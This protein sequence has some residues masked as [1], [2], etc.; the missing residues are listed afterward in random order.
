MIELD[1]DNEGR[2]V[3]YMPM[4]KC[5]NCGEEIDEKNERCL[6]CGHDLKKEITTTPKRRGR[7][8]KVNTIKCEDCKIEYDIAL[9]ECPNCGCPKP[10]V[11]SN[12]KQAIFEYI[13]C[14]ECGSKISQDNT[15]CPNCGYPIQH[16]VNL[17][18]VIVKDDK[19]KKAK[20]KKQNKDIS[21]IFFFIFLALFFLAGCF[22]AVVLSNTLKNKAHNETDTN[23]IEYKINRTLS[24]VSEDGFEP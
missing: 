18:P 2:E 3:L 16:K 15:E 11:M 1:I 13:F 24:C 12:P 20:I 6:K 10:E 17:A 9:T 5:P 4:I 7:P 8:K 23:P 14:E 21:K 19:T 22:T